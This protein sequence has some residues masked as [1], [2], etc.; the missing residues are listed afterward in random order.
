M[1][2][3]LILA[4]SRSDP[5]R[6][7]D[8]F[9]PLSLPILAAAAPEHDYQLADL[10]WEDEPDLDEPVDLVGIS[11]RCTA[12]VR[13]Y[14]LADAF[15][16]RGVP[17]VLGGPQ[18]SAV[19]H[20]A[21]AHADAVVVGEAEDLWPLLTE[22]LRRGQL[23][24]FYVCAP[25]PFDARGHSCRQLFQRPVLAGRPL[26]RRDLLRRK[27]RFDTVSALRGC[28]IGCDFCS[29]TSLF[30]ARQRRRPVQEVVREIDGLG[31]HFYLLDDTVFGRPA[32]YDYYIELYQALARLPRR[33]FWTGQANLDAVGDERGREVIRQAVRSGLVY[34]AVGLESVNAATL[35]RSGALRKLGKGETADPIERMKQRLRF[36][37]D[38]GVIVSGWFVI[39]YEDDDLETWQ[40]SWEFCQEMRLIPVIL[41]VKVLPGT[42]LHARLAREGKLDETRRINFVHPDMPEEQV[43]QAMARVR[44][45][46][47]CWRQHWRRLAFYLPRF[48]D[49]R[50]RRAIFCHVLQSRIGRGVDL[51]EAE[52][53]V[54][55]SDEE[56][57]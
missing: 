41:P 20:R 53:Y 13:A 5:L 26:P 2:I 28:P 6:E 50:V 15:R 55:Q 54:P 3:K 25:Q 12:E 16:S 40:R 7:N 42:Q 45:Q 11:M 24:R 38:L 57:V 31:Q 52:F 30:G 37:Q 35:R 23:K 49:E 4:A 48:P 47:Y 29:V 51:A 8:P 21:L 44:G 56:P 39:G 22:D 18:A 17:V 19:P 9:M 34:A 27:Y 46:A 14:E 36:I 32:S 33:R 10:L 1:R 43:L